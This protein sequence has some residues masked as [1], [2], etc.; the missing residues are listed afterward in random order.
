MRLI[1]ILLMVVVA[2]AL[3]LVALVV[4]LPGEK[5]A[6]IAADQVRAQTGREL[7][8][9]GEVGIS[10]YPILGV[11]TGPVQLANAEWSDAGPMFRA[12]SAQI[13]V[14]AMSLIGGTIRITQI[15][16][17]APDVLLE[18]TKDGRA[19]WDLFPKGAEAGQ[20]TTATSEGGGAMGGLV[21]ESLAVRDARLR[22]VDH[23]G[24]S[25]DIKDVDAALRWPDTAGPA[26]IDLTLRPAAEAV[27]IAA[28]VDD[29]EGLLGGEISTLRADVA[30]AGGTVAFDGR[31]GMDPQAAGRVEANLPDPDAF[32]AALGLG[33]AGLDGKATFQGDVTYTK[34]GQLALR[35]GQVSALGNAASVEADVNMS[36]AKPR[37]SA[38]VAANAV[39]LAALMGGGGESS[40]TGWSKA[41][42]DASGLGAID[43]DISLAA[44]SVELGSV[45]LGRVRASISIDN[46]RAV[47]TLREINAYDG[48][49]SGTIVANNRGGFSTSA[50]L[51]V[52][53]IEMQKALG[54]LAGIDKFTGK[55]N[56]NVSV[57]GAGGSMHAIMNS[58]SGDGAV[59]VGQGK[60]LGID[61]DRLLRG[62]PGGGVTV[63]D[64]LGATWSMSKGILSNDDLLLSLPNV[65]AKG[66]GTIGIGPRTLDYLFTPQL[67]NETDDGLAVPVE[68][69]GTWDSPKI[70]PRLDKAFGSDVELEIEEKKEE[71]KSKAEAKIKEK[72]GVTET[73]EGQSTEDALKQKLEDKAKDKLKSLLGGD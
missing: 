69:K 45:N 36:G 5:I 11:K 47:I 66:E 49:A 18:V 58:L 55:A 7:V 34:D 16:L 24:E 59:N 9:D 37:V 13:G 41:P 25:F 44:E 35:S 14:D 27:Q 17:G 22:Y 61:L 65:I 28:V 42:I 19:N 53:D 21:L 60:I 20:P 52:K 10:W 46:S 43:G 57:L 50:K 56:V 15:D 73:E 3:G 51:N 2:V 40:G 54:E 32:M 39:S 67:R 6:K 30:A 4:L 29:L 12:E 71:L 38:R 48:V 64:S 33:P 26:E 63:F 1:R 68:I 8:F 70:V 62:Q 31:A 23:G 72:L